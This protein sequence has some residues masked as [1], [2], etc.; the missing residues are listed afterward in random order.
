M[1]D[2]GTRLGLA[3]TLAL[4]VAGAVGDASAQDAGGITITFGVSEQLEHLRRSNTDPT[5][6]AVTDLTALYITETRTQR[7]SFSAGVSLRAVKG[8]GIDGIETEVLNPNVGLA[9]TRTGASAALSV[10]ASYTQNDISFLRPLSDFVDA[11]GVVTLPDDF[12][13]LTG[14]GTRS[15][16]GY[17]ASLSLRENRPFGLVLS[18]S[19]SELNY[20]DTTDPDLVD[21]SRVEAGIG[22]RF[23]LNEVTQA[24]LDLGHSRFESA[25]SETSETTSL[26]GAVVFERPLGSLS[27]GLS[28]TDTDSGRQYGFSF[29]R[30]YQPSP[31]MSLSGEFGV[32]RASEGERVLT[33]AFSFAQEL[34]NGTV[35]A[36]FSREVSLTDEDED[37][38][39]TSFAGGYSTDLSPNLSLSVSAAFARSDR[40]ETDEVTDVADLGVSVGYAL[41]EDWSL[42]SGYS[43]QWRNE[44]G[45]DT[46]TTDTISI[47]LSR[48][49][50]W[51]Y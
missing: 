2:W 32:T 1:S 22:F 37:R 27:F 26:A 46:T 42:T 29:G 3:S 31:T 6:Q 47:G 7:L 21:T 39:V 4:G 18:V 40:T 13:D 33:G 14:T 51:R 10:S 24:T 50:Q 49:F 34:P 12:D 20:T 15:Q 36:R 41:T 44:D 11:G 28:A 38:V 25:A 5:T 35:S 43:R 23:D 16:F 45:A 30:S 19:G 48:S 8:P 17:S 9:Y